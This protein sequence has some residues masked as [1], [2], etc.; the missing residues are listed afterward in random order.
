MRD[1]Q[2]WDEFVLHN[3]LF[4]GVTVA[5]NGSVEFV[6]QGNLSFV[7]ELAEVRKEDNNTPIFEPKPVVEMQPEAPK[8]VAS[9]LKE[10]PNKVTVYCQPGISRKNRDEFYG[11]VRGEKIDYG[12]PFVFEGVVIDG[13]DVALVLWSP[14]DKVTKGS[15]LF[16]QN[17]DKR[18]WKVVAT[19]PNMQGWI[20]HTV[21]SDYQPQFRV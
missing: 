20:L 2:M 13:D 5:D 17:R 3:F 7:E 4:K 15:V 14:T 6:H 8:S 11:E 12:E 19:E 21:I 16:P 9:I 10:S 18:W 1:Q